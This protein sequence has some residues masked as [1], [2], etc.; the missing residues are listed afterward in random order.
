LVDRTALGIQATNAFQDVRLENLRTFAEAYDLKELA[1]AAP[2]TDTRVQIATVQ[3]L[4]QRILYAQDGAVPAVDWYD[5]IVV[6]ECHR[7]YLL[8]REMSDRE[9]AYRSEDDYISSYRRVLDH[10]DAVKIGLTAT[11]AL[12]TTEIFG[13]PVYQY[14]YREAVI[15]GYLIDH[16]PPT[17]IITALAEDGIHFRA[18]EEVA[19]YLPATGEVQLALLP[20]DV[21]VEVE[22]FNKRVVNENFNRVVCEELAKHIDPGLDGKTLVFCATDSHANDVVRLLKDAFKAQY[23]AVDDSAVLKITG[24]ADKPL[25]LIRRYKNERLPNVA[26]TVDLLTTGID[27][28]AICNLVFLRRV[29]SRILYEQ[30][31]GRAT[32]RCDA[33]GKEVFRIFDAVDL[34]KALDAYSAMKP[35]VVNPKIGFAALVDELGKQQTEQHQ[36]EVVEQLVAKLHRKKRKLSKDALERFEAAA[37]MDP[38]ALLRFLRNEGLAVA[39]KWFVEHAGL[40]ELLDR[41]RGP[42]ASPVLISS[43]EDE[44]RRVVEGDSS[45]PGDYLEGFRKYVQD[46]LNAVPA[47]LVVTQRPRELTRKQL[48]ELKLALDQAGYSETHLRSAWR[49]QTNQDIA[50]SIVGYIRQAALGDPLKPYE[51]RVAVAMKKLLG[52]RAWTAPQRQWLVRIGNQLTQETVVDVEAFDRGQ[53]KAEGGFARLNNVFDGKLEQILGDMNEAIWD[54]GA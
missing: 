39:Q 50:A 38:N 54:K 28:P 34:Y 18:R 42:G 30:M 12:H 25:E 11:P 40:G 24:A 15:D 3:A 53:F 51:E 17:R 31:L 48:K 32:R 4:V 10:F 19:T 36:G 49:S 46:N 33:I 5:C 16:E 13:P 14:S 22:Q 41:E 29:R 20:D 9:L 37:G 2:E 1:D 23:G 47:L 43:H 7:G 21:D 45:P 26:V 6:D 27:V 52:S 35:V 8:D 44:L